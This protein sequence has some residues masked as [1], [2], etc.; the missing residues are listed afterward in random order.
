MKTFCNPTM[1]FWLAQSLS[2]VTIIIDIVRIWSIT[3]IM[4]YNENQFPGSL[5]IGG[6][7]TLDHTTSLPYIWGFQSSYRMWEIGL[8][9]PSPRQ[10]ISQ[11][12]EMLWDSKTRRHPTRYKNHD[13]STK[14]ISILLDLPLK[15]QWKEAGFVVVVGSQ[16]VAKKTLGLS[17]DRFKIQ[18]SLWGFL[19]AV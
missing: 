3:H 5:N 16:G 1:R 18:R 6:F 9:R 11:A 15:Q 13:W 19:K 17:Q 4:Y 2:G 10:A 7:F 14:P 12:A 8:T